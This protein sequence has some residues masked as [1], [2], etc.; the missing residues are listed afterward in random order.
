MI[1]LLPEDSTTVRI[2]S[3]FDLKSAATQALAVGL[4][5][6]LIL[7]GGLVYAQSVPHAAHHAHHKPAT[8]ATVLCSW[9]CAAGQVLE[10]S[11]FSLPPAGGL[12]SL[13]AQHIPDEP[14]TV[15]LPPSSSR[16]PPLLSS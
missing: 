4:T 8:H 16:G 2:T 13:L 15:T 11:I 14:L 9:M 1:S 7:L 3:R 5:V 6:C 10:G 12:V